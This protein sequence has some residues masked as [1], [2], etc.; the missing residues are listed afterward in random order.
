MQC[1]EICCG[2][3]FA[4]PLG[5]PMPPWV[6]PKVLVGS[7]CAFPGGF[8]FAF[9]WGLDVLSP[10]GQRQPHQRRG[11]CR[12]GEGHHR[13]LHCQHCGQRP[14]LCHRL[15]CVLPQGLL[16]YILSFGDWCGW[17]CMLVARGFLKETLFPPCFAIQTSHMRLNPQSLTAGTC[18]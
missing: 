4:F 11:R 1:Q 10:V 13:K 9:M 2:F 6:G 5:G 14:F 15:R 3:F 12:P 17:G 18:C 16:V 7:L 8:T